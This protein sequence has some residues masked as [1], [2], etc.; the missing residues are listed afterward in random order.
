MAV[1]VLTGVAFLVWLLFAG[2]GEDADERAG[3]PLA[4]PAYSV[5]QPA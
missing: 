4:A 5:S 2:R 1:A 3:A